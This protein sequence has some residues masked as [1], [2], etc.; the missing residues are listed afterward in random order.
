MRLVARTSF[1]L[2]GLGIVGAAWLLLRPRDPLRD[3][4]PALDREVTRALA[5]ADAEPA[6][7]LARARGSW[8]A[9]RIYEDLRDA[10]ADADGGGAAERRARILP[11]LERWGEALAAAHTLPEYRED[12]AFWRRLDPATT[13]ALVVRWRDMQAAFA[14]GDLA[15]D[16]VKVRLLAHAAAFQAAGDRLGAARTGYNLANICLKLGELPEARQRFAD[17]LAESRRSGLAAETCDALNSLALFAVVAGDTAAAG[18]LAEALALARRSHLAA[19]AGR[20]LTVAG[21]QARDQGRFART[22]DLMEEAVAVCGQLG[23]AWQGLPYLIYLM[24]FHAG[25]DDWRQVAVL[26]PR[27]ELLL[28]E[29]TTAGG[30]PLMTQRESLRLRELTL[31]LALQTGGA[32]SALAEYPALIE[33]ASRQPFAEVTYVYDRAVR[34][35]LAVGRPQDALDMLPAA[36]A[37]AERHGQPELL[38][39]LLAEVE[40]NLESGRSAA[41]RAALARFDAEAAARA[42]WARDL[43]LDA[44]ALRAILLARDGDPD[45]AAALR[46]GLVRLAD[47]VAG[48]DGSGLAYL[49]LQRNRLLRRALR[50]VAGQPGEV[51]YGLELLW[52][53][54]PAW[55]GDPDLPRGLADDPAGLARELAMA[56]RRAL[57][58]DRLH[59]LYV[60][61][62]D[63]VARWLVGAEELRCDTLAVAAAE[64]RT[65][66]ESLIAELARDPGNSAAPASAAFAAEAAALA[67]VLLPA[68][69][70]EDPRPRELFVSGEGA[71]ALLPFGV[72]DLE[73][74]PRYAPLAASVAV[75]ALRDAGPVAGAPARSTGVLVADPVVPTRLRRRY[76]GL[77]DLAATADEVAAVGRLLP[78]TVVLGGESA[79]LAGLGAQWGGA[80]VLYFACHTVRSPESPFRTF[81]PL[82][83]PPGAEESL[84]TSF[85]DVAS[86]RGADLAGCRLVVLASCASGAPYVSGR[87]WAPSLGDAFLDA[88]AGAALQTLWRVRDEDAARLPGLFL[89]GW[90]VQGLGPVAA[91][92]AACR[93]VM[94]GPDGQPRHPFGWAAYVLELRDV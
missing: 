88:G 92:A 87:V 12:A 90:R 54:L 84:Q 43:Q 8:A 44:C 25:L 93:A 85:L 57:G 41:A 67:E 83:A 71:L 49:E 75:A 66:V 45:A 94:V 16:S 76:P 2:L 68:A 37:H 18:L 63:R 91:L 50:E 28:R 51:A 36:V 79:T 61:D 86:I 53:R 6:T 78:R 13:A 64:I 27:A 22:M 7:R 35:L 20:A 15:P 52:R 17:V 89:Q 56:R 39:L 1:L 9:V 31:R 14:D 62:G 5:A 74:G 60:E 55:L 82:S 77:L 19:R 3:W 38:N 4:L 40:A 32:D 81:L 47:L 70:R 46:A 11:G 33:A 23:E 58:P 10:L 42:E 59:L 72:L 65:R 26:A 69:I 34:M 48:S 29:A 73:P 24:R 30:D 80:D 21:I